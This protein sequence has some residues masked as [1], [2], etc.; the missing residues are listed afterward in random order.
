MNPVD[1]R[2]PY[3]T[4]KGQVIPV[5]VTKAYGRVEVKR[6]SVLTWALQRS[7]RLSLRSSRFT[8]RNNAGTHSKGGW[9]GPRVCLVVQERREIP[10]TCRESNSGSSS[11][12]PSHYC[13]D[14]NFSNIPSLHL[15]QSIAL[16]PWN[17]PT[18]ILGQSFFS[19]MCYYT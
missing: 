17:L 2:T 9:V 18:K 15:A 7:M 5:H 8:P 6:H 3:F 4:D 19:A 1:I 11:P 16:S 12:Y 14:T 13:F 10:C